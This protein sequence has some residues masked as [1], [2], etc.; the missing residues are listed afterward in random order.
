[1]IEIHGLCYQ[2]GAFG[3]NDVSL[4]IGDREYLIILGPTGAGKTVFL[5]CLAGLHRLKQGRIL[6]DGQDVGRQAPEQ[7]GIGYVPQDYVLFPFLDVKDNITFGL[8]SKRLPPAEVKARLHHLAELMGISHLLERDVRSLSGGEKQRV[9]IARALAPRPRILLMDEPL[10]NLDLQTSNRLRLELKHIHHEMGVSTVHVSH[11]HLEAEEM[12]DR[13]AIISS[14]VLQ[15]VGTP[16]EIFFNPGNDTVAQ[17]VGS[18]N[19]LECD[20]CRMVSPGLAE[21]DCAGMTILLP[22]DGGPIRK[23]AVFP[24]D[25]YISDVPPPGPGINRYRGRVTEVSCRGSLVRLE[26]AVFANSLTVDMPDY[27]F[28]E[29]KLEPGC[30]VYLILKLRRLRALEVSQTVT[31]SSGM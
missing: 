31:A 27:L 11:N 15:Q 24:H 16:Q 20:A 1:M 19:I 23:I 29:M 17:F 25:I 7:R 21:V 8:K 28:K 3:L 22:H 26:V 14:G 30:D 10:S 6:I 5:E 9:A 13:I 12:A 4:T 18:S 2:A